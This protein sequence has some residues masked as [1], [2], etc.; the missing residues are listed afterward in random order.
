MLTEKTI[1][2]NEM[3]RY[4]YSKYNFSKAFEN[5]MSF[6]DGLTE[7]GKVSL[8]KNVKEKI[9]KTA[10]ELEEE[11]S[12]SLIYKMA[13]DLLDQKAK[14]II[15]MGK[16]LQN[17]KIPDSLKEKLEIL[18]NDFSERITSHY[19]SLSNIGKPDCNT[20]KIKTVAYGILS[21]DVYEDN[22]DSFMNIIGLT[23]KKLFEN[24]KTFVKENK[25]LARIDEYVDTLK[26]L[27]TVNKTVQKEEKDKK[28][29]KRD[30]I[31]F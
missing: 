16:L 22:F 21:M 31:D 13:V 14:K 25:N 6:V 19:A 10:K 20:D 29:K 23:N 12:F 24:V 7:D 26:E 18:R 5:I 4:D 11:K 15:E 9:E 3:M 1:S 28:G 8:T 2:I 27:S 17:E 30:F